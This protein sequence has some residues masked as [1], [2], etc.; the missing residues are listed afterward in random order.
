MPQSQSDTAVASE[1]VRQMLYTIDLASV[2]RCII[3]LLY[4]LSLRVIDPKH[5]AL[6]L[7]LRSIKSIDLILIKVENP[8]PAFNEA[9]IIRSFEEAVF[10]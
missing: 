1:K 6:D 3:Q 9:S 2:E 4:L 10:E 5:S 7:S 8:C